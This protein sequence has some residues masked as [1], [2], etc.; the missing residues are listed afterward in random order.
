M[1]LVA[2]AALRLAAGDTASFLTAPQRDQQSAT[3]AATSVDVSA[4]GRYVAFELYAQLRTGRHQR[5]SRRLRARPPDEARDAR[6][7][8]D[9]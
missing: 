2:G 8:D 6:V 4:D 9:G 3:F 1:L 7:G 5:P